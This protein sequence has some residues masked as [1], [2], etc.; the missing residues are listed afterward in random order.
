MMDRHPFRPAHIHIIATLD[1]Y[2][3]LTTQIFDRKDPYLTN[4]S[5][6]A[7]KDSLV[8]DFVP[9]KDDPQ[10]GLELNYDVKLVPAETSNVNSA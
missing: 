3:P 7:V 6:F 2:K 9:R 5:V 8:V 1:G 4:D 10:A